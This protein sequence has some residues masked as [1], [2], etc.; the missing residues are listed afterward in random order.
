MATREIVQ[1]GEG[2]IGDFP[3]TGQPE[4]DGLLRDILSRLN[5]GLS[6]GLGLDGHQAGNFRGQTFK[7]VTPS[8]A[9][10]QFDVVHGL[11]RVP[12]GYNVLDRDQ[13]GGV[14]ST[15]RGSWTESII[16]LK[17]SLAS[18]TIYLEVF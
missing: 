18:T 14:Y 13:A 16:S 8:V 17:C 4:L 1:D 12:I 2:M 3:P 9:D 5:G 15:S 6:H 7:I 11:R 10:Q